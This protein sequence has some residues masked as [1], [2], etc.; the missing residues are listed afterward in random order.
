MI[1][2]CTKDTERVKTECYFTHTMNLWP[3]ALNK[4]VGRIYEF[5]KVN[6]KKTP[7]VYGQRYPTHFNFLSF[8]YSDFFALRKAAVLE[9]YVFSW[10]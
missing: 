8:C 1:P 3:P 4:G 7:V 10:K 6:G 5:P 2:Y 9:I